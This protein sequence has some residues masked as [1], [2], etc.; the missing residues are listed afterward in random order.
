MPDPMRTVSFKLPEH[1]D[2]LL[3]E[4]AKQRKASRSGVVREA[5]AAYAA[6]SAPTVTMRVDELVG[7]VAGPPDLSTNPKHLR[8]YGR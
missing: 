1:L 2:E 3:T 8:G 4:L 6:H 5:I 7:T